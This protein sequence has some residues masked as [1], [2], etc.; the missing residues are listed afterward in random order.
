MIRIMIC[1]D[2]REA[3]E[4]FR[5][6]LGLDEE[7]RVVGAFASAEQLIDSIRE[8]GTPDVVMMDIGLPEMSGIEATRIIHEKW[9]QINILILT[10]FEEEEKIL[11]AIQA[12]ASGYV[13][14][15]TRPGELTSQ[16]KALYR[17]G[18]P[19]SPQIART[20]LGELRKEKSPADH[21]DYNLTPRELDV[22]KGI[23]AGY[24][25]REIADRYNISGS[26]VKKHI[27]HIYKKLNVS[28]RVEFM[29]KMYG[30]NGPLSAL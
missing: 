26:T 24:T 28:S 10:I 21:V 13:L 8:V 16:I 4:G 14:K 29:K 25:Y 22:V 2:E 7:I 20:L 1:E 11:S 23:I 3:R 19:I 18:S 6:L 27:L 30:P 12:G 17:G 5:Y 9:P 15:N